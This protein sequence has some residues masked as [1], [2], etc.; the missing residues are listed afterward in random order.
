MREQLGSLATEIATERYG[1]GSIELHSY[2]KD[3]AAADNDGH[4]HQRP[5]AYG[6]AFCATARIDNAALKDLLAKKW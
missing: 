1:T 2:F 3:L 4:G 5:A 6:R